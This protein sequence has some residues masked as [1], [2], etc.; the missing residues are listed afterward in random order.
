MSTSYQVGRLPTACSVR[1]PSFASVVTMNDAG[2][3]LESSGFVFHRTGDISLGWRGEKYWIYLPTIGEMRRIEQYGLMIADEI[4]NDPI[5]KEA[6]DKVRQVF[7]KVTK[8][9]EEGETVTAADFDGL[10]E[11]DAADIMRRFN[12][13][14]REQSL[15]W[16]RKVVEICGS[17]NWPS[18][19]DDLPSP[20]RNREL[21][22]QI[23]A[24]WAA[25]PLPES[26]NGAT[27][28]K[29]SQT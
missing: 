16:F 28:A 13:M 22:T 9:R 21:V 14:A 24:H 8:A 23:K 25:V 19:D 27:T 29:I 26:P 1:E 2:G 11:D 4:E 20:V 7:E 10:G 17:D 5:S 12:A 15:K 3:T 6:N 18:D